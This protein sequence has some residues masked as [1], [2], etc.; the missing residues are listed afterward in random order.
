[1]GM[2]IPLSVPTVGDREKTYVAEAIEGGWIAPVGPEIGVFEAAIARR[3][4]RQRAVAVS[5]GTAALHLM[6]VTAGIGPGDRVACPTLTFVASINAITQAGATPVLVDCD[7]TGNLD[8]ELL[9]ELMEEQEKAG[10]PITA[11]LPVDLYGKIAD[12]ARIA[13]IADRHGAQVLVDAA[14]SMGSVREGRPA[15]SHGRAA[16]FSFNGNKIVT[17]SSGGAVVTDDE[18]FA[19]RVLHLSTQAREPV[20]HYLHREPG[21]N[22]RLSNLLA[23]LGRAQ[24][25]QLDG[26][27]AARRAHRRRYRELCERVPGL[28]IMGG[29]DA[30]DNCWLTVLEV[31]P[32]LHVHGTSED[33]AGQDLAG[34]SLSATVERLGRL[35]AVKGIETRRLFTPLHTQPICADHDRYPRLVRGVAQRMF[36]HTLVVPS[37][38]ASSPRQVQEVCRHIE[39]ALAPR[40]RPA[41][42]S[43]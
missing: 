10:T 30:G 20:P 27:L 34:G 22:Y 41:A 15:G 14:E 5:S 40:K 7:T 33:H 35:L 6:L 16:A 4:G 9:A 18:E 38:P 11:V 29:D 37:S 8:P 42:V 23:A 39:G 2:R 1:M 19:D 26:F 25:E 3:A 12:H 32:D 31:D 21:Y 43:R 36:E 13:A 17:A 24:M 28:R